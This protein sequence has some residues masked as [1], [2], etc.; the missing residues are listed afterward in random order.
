MIKNSPMKL[1]HG[2]LMITVKKMILYLTFYEVITIELLKKLQTSLFWML[3]NILD[4]TVSLLLHMDGQIARWPVESY[5]LNPL[6][7]K[8]LNDNI[9]ENQFQNVI[10]VHHIRVAPEH[11]INSII[12]ERK[13]GIIKI[14]VEGSEPELLKACKY[15]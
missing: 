10:T 3:E 14:D 11:P 12:N 6:Y 7:F 15:L 8:I 1:G 13:I 5:E 2:S 4:I 9:Q